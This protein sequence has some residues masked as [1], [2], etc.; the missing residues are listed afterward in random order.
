MNVIE[1]GFDPSWPKGVTFVRC[2]TL[3][4]E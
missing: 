1:R 4:S 2:G 3:I